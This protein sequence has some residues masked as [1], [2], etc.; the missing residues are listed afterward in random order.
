MIGFYGLKRN[1]AIFTL[2]G[3]K[4]RSKIVESQR[5]NLKTNQS[6]T[7]RNIWK[8][9]AMKQLQIRY[10]YMCMGQGLSMLKGPNVV[11]RVVKREFTWIV[12]SAQ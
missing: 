12:V 10:V 9:F 11:T 2:D 5:E 4:G 8:M 6:L 1:H 3:R 7:P